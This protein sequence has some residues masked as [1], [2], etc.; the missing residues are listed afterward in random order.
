MYDA[1]YFLLYRIFLRYGKEDLF[2]PVPDCF[3][4]IG[5]HRFFRRMPHGY[6]KR[7]VLHEPLQP[8]GKGFLAVRRQ[9]PGLP[10]FYDLI[11]AAAGGESHYGQARA[12]RFGHG[13][14]KA[15][16]GAGDGEDIGLR[17]FL[18]DLFL[19]SFQ[20]YSPPPGGL[21]RSAGPAPLCSPYFPCPRPPRPTPEI[22]PPGGRTLR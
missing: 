7:P 6:A 1:H 16:K 11:D 8:F 18:K 4:S 19:R 15:F 10:V 2:P 17:I 13:V 22:S 21:L 14:R 12:H 5:L 9:Y 20:D 3:R